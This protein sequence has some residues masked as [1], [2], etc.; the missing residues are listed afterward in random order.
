MLQWSNFPCWQQFET[1]L[2]NNTRNR[3]VFRGGGVPRPPLWVV[4]KV[5]LPQNSTQSLAM[6]P[7]LNWAENLVKKR[8]ESEWKPFFLSFYLF[9]L[10]LNLG[11]KTDWM[12]AKTFF[13][14]FYYF[15]GLYLNL[16]RKTNWIW[17]VLIF[18]VFIFISL[19]L[20]PF[21]SGYYLPFQIPGYAP[22][23]PLSKILR[24][25]LRRNINKRKPSLLHKLVFHDRIKIP[26]QILSPII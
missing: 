17:V 8:T 4:S 20:R 2:K 12:W 7:P 16:G 24:T 11:R 1:D 3:G 25:L 13:Y 19:E 14:F 26:I 10:H 22:D 21:C 5:W 9:G 6:A 23:P 18:L 15:F